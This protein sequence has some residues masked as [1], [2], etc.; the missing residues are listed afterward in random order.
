MRKL[1]DEINPSQKSINKL[2]DSTEKLNQNFH[3]DI[4]RFFYMKKIQ[5]P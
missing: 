1:I 4:K 5:E 3:K 2:E